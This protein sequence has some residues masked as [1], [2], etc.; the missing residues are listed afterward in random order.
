MFNSL[1]ADRKLTDFGPAEGQL[2]NTDL[3]Y[4]CDK[5]ELD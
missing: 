1:V 2:R 3:N 5:C 4:E